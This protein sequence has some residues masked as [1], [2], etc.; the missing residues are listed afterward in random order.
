M[1]TS[2]P[3]TSWPTLQAVWHTLPG[4]S[5]SLVQATAGSFA[6]TLSWATHVEPGHCASLV[7]SCAVLFLHAPHCVPPVRQLTAGAFA[8]WSWGVLKS[9][10]PWSR[11]MP[12]GTLASR[13]A[14]SKRIL[15]SSSAGGSGSTVGSTV[16]SPVMLHTG[17]PRMSGTQCALCTH[18]GFEPQSASLVHAAPPGWLQ[19]PTPPV[20]SASVPQLTAG[21]F[22]QTRFVW[23]LAVAAA[24]GTTLR[25]RKFATYTVVPSGER[26][27][28]IGP[29]P[30]PSGT[31]RMREMPVFM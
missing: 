3:G 9:G 31:A 12:L 23:S 27:T 7:Q 17:G 5:P 20:Q 28:P 18:G 2:A 11:P 29:V 1:L 10:A 4:Q 6:H 22:E 21:W 13:A 30:I 16:R 24:T 25:E 8:Q 14:V 15:P 19:N 26:P